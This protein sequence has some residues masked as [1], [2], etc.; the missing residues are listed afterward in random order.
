MQKTQPWTGKIRTIDRVADDR[1]TLQTLADRV[2]VSRSTVSNAFN[3]PDQ[4]SDELRARILAVADELGYAGPDPAARSL[5]GGRVGAVGL[6]QHTIRYAV[7]DAA[8]RLL[9]DGVAE[10][11]EDEG[12]ALVLLPA[13]PPAPGRPDVLRTALV[14]GVIFHTSNVADGRR[15]AVQDRGLP[16][17][18]LDGRR[19]DADLYVGVDDRGGARSAAEH[20][21]ALGHRRLAVVTLAT[22][23]E[24]RAV[25][26]ARYEGYREAFVAAGVA[27]D[28]VPVVNGGGLELHEFEAR[29]RALL[30]RPDRP[31]AVL[32]MSDEVAAGIVRVAQALG[33]RVP[34]DLSVVGFD[35]SPTAFA[36]HPALTT[37]RQD[38][39]RKG[40]LAVRLVLGDLSEGRQ[41][42]LPVE[43]VVRGS[44]A[45]PP[46]ADC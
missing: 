24:T 28:S 1:V 36:V 12:L 37:V 18:I 3:R 29:M 22:D 30:D 40:R 41:V 27:V 14:D 32:A 7:N 44:T 34:D 6:V 43:L 19:D 9:L 25:S 38:F 10:V 39:Q 15:R 31:T 21:L 13:N 2:G 33:L 23:A 5:R 20:V 17:V 42:V 11:C 45:P 8:N 35:D 4:L 16:F 26:T 46:A